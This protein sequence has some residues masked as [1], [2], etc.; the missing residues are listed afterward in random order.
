[1]S[2]YLYKLNYINYGIY[3]PNILCACSFSLLFKR[4]EFRVGKDLLVTTCLSS[5][6]KNIFAIFQN[7]YQIKSSLFFDNRTFGGR[8]C[9]ALCDEPIPPT[10][11]VLKF[12]NKLTYHLHCFKCTNCQNRFCVG[13]SV[14]IADPKHL[15]CKDCDH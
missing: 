2:L 3:I 6:Q 8:G 13:D 11:H 10:E 7:L 5:L 12:N 14:K 9:C 15:L 4:S 1:M